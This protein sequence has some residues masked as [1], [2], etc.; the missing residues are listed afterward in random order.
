MLE[1]RRFGL[2][3]SDTVEE[4]ARF[5]DLR[6]TDIDPDADWRRTSINHERRKDS[7]VLSPWRSELRGKPISSQRI[8]R[9]RERLTRDQV[10]IIER[11]CA[12][13]LRRFGYQATT[14]S[15]PDAN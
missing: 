10:A 12:A 4:I 14:G 6:L 2:N 1:R 7:A 15:I 9:F 11:E 3:V 5:T 13:Y 8:G